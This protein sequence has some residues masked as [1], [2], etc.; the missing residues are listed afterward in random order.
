MLKTNKSG[1]FEVPIWPIKSLTWGVAIFAPTNVRLNPLPV[2]ASPIA[3]RGIFLIGVAVGSIVSISV[4]GGSTLIAGVSVLV[5]G[6][7]V[8]GVGV[9]GVGGDVFLN[10]SEKALANDA[11]A[12]R[13]WYLR[14]SRPAK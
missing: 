9:A 14:C 7:G 5:E 13:I 4:V 6:V 10:P 2:N 1:F 8:A 12:D 3:K 11:M